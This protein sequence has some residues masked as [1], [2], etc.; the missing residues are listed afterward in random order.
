MSPDR[1][2]DYSF[3]RPNPAS[4]K[5]AGYVGVARY[6][7][8]GSGK[9]LTAG[10][11]AGIHA[12]GLAVAVVW[13]TSANRMD[14]GAPAGAADA[15]E[16]NA[17]ADGLGIPDDRP[18]YFANDQNLATPAHRAYMQAAHDTSKRPAG[19]YGSTALIDV[20]AVF[21]CRYGWKVQTWGGP[22]PNATLEQMPNVHPDIAG[23]DVNDVLKPDWGGWPNTGGAPAPTTP[24]RRKTKSM[25]L[26]ND[27]VTWYLIPEKG[28]PRIIFDADK[29]KDGGPALM[30]LAASGIPHTA[31]MPLD[32]LVGLLTDAGAP[33]EVIVVAKATPAK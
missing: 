19:P 4:I 26:S 20:A 11:L 27:N 24:P 12:A 17:Q 21:G 9:L 25:L 6:L 22:T 23:T 31:H 16:A 13:E 14:G 29:H 5:A 32:L 33:E 3:S 28:A 1:V 7:G 2:V 18:I 10:E 8:H 30:E 15:R